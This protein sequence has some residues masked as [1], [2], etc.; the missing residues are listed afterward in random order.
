[1]RKLHYMIAL[2]FA[3][4]ASGCAPV[5]EES[6]DS[7]RLDYTEFS[8]AASAEKALLAI[9][10]SGSWEASLPE[11]T[12]W[13]R[14]EKTS[15][16]GITQNR[17]ILVKNTGPVRK[18]V[19]TV[20]AD[21]GQRLTVDVTQ[22]AS[23]N[24]Y[25]KFEPNIIALPADALTIEVPIVTTMGD[26]YVLP[27]LEGMISE[28]LD[29]VV[30]DCQVSEA[31]EVETG[32]YHRVLTLNLTENQ[33]GSNRVIELPAQMTSSDG[34]T[35]GD[36]LK[37]TQGPDKA[38]IS[39][40]DRYVV[41]KNAAECSLSVNHNLGFLAE[42]MDL[43]VAY[44]GEVQEFI[45]DAIL[46]PNLVKFKVSAAESDRSAEIKVVFNGNGLNLSAV[47][48]F[49]QVFN[50]MPRKASIQE[51]VSLFV[52]GV[53][54]Y[55]PADIYT[56]YVELYVVGG[57]E[58]PNMAQNI[59]TSANSITTD[60][61]DRTVYMQ[62][63]A[64]GAKH[65]F[66][67]RFKSA[68]DNVFDHGALVQLALE[69]C[70]LRK[71]S[72]PERYTVENVS[73]SNITVVSED[74]PI[75]PNVRS[76][77]S[78][79]PS[80]IYTYCTLENVEFQVKEGAF[81]NVREKAAIAN[82][83]SVDGANPAMD[84]A[85]N[86]L[87]DNAGNAIY[88]LI[89]MG[90]DWRRNKV[91][92]GA[93][94]ISGVVVHQQMP[95]WGGN[96]GT[97]SIRPLG[98]EDVQ[99]EEASEWNTLAEWVLTKE[100]MN[101]LDYLWKDGYSGESAV[102]LKQNKMFATNGADAILYSENLEG[103]CVSRLHTKG[104]TPVSIAYGYKNLTQGSDGM[105]VGTALTFWGNAAG[106]YQWNSTSISGYNGIVMELSTM[107]ASGSAV[108]V[109]FSIAAG[110][111]DG[112]TLA[113]QSSTSFPIYWTV[114]YSTDGSTWTEAVNAATGSTGFEMRTVPATFT[115][116]SKAPHYGTTAK[117]DI[118]TQS[119][120]GFGYVPHRFILPGSVLGH[121]SVKVRIRPSSDIIMCFN[122][123][124]DA[125]I[126]SAQLRAIPQPNQ[127]TNVNHGLFLEDVVIQYK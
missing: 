36:V 74:N 35:Y 8:V 109:G 112:T 22:K 16:T 7:L 76:I 127:K 52:D 82:P 77:A 37:V 42:H 23:S 87:Y 90:C 97:Y 75:E 92:S 51:F 63:A 94:N 38:Y 78:L 89:N 60:E 47:T 39:V 66:R 80:D 28:S 12:T 88:T 13:A 55:A 84:G 30:A 17:I 32:T 95:R 72:S 119:D 100:T 24:S 91:P 59:N 40:T 98:K 45:Q 125:G 21:N 86:L 105:S 64:T 27:M 113:S 108:S 107:S 41:N 81:T 117:I 5:F 31:Q 14:L 70:S 83:L 121:Q 54:T 85:A 110:Y 10:Y 114:E 69:G 50:L 96:V 56:D 62:D 9:Y 126:A 73:A 99:M 118:N 65:G 61:N 68:D 102:T 123:Q 11:G 15:G 49:V 120:M 19:V 71:E 116:E 57:A 2:L 18:T 111:M 6:Y 46:E 103:N 101:H 4:V 115:G 124:W 122:A 58:N 79:S 106:W 43:Q 93:G 20:T 25:L 48:E 3:V 44:A 53:H 67:V 26:D 1:M 34:K 29:G 33:T 104:A